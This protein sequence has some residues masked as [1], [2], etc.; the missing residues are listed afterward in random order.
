MK[1]ISLGFKSLFLHEGKVDILLLIIFLT[2]NFLVLVNTVRHNP[3]MGY[4]AS[5]HLE[6]IQVLPQLASFDRQI[7]ALTS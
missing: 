3:K 7:V 1:Q 4:D 6:Y 2:I 5:H